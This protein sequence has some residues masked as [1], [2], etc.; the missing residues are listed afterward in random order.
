M[1]TREKRIDNYAN[2]TRPNIAELD[3]VPATKTPEKKPKKKP[4]VISSSDSNSNTNSRKDTISI[5]EKIRINMA[6]NPKY[7]PVDLV[8]SYTDSKIVVFYDKTTLEIIKFSFVSGDIVTNITLD[9]LFRTYNKILLENLKNPSKEFL[10]K[11]DKKIIN[12][13]LINHICNNEEPKDINT[14]TRI[15]KII[16]RQGTQCLLRIKHILEDPE[17]YKTDLEPIYSYVNDL[18]TA[19]K[20]SCANTQTI[21]MTTPSYAERRKR[22]A[23]E[24]Q[25]VVEPQRTR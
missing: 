15:F 1:K 22:T 10:L 4:R 11:I 14:F 8:R 13:I 18:K 12:D 3:S 20:A 21:I 9:N 6:N 24:Y 7:R 19:F 5:I 23:D 25:E 17:A 16:K 2:I